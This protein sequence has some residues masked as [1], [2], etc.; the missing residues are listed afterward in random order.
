MMDWMKPRGA[1]ALAAMAALL[2]ISAEAAT[3]AGSTPASLTVT[4]A[5]AAVYQI[6][7]QVPP[8]VAGMQPKLVLRHDSQGAR[9]IAGAFW[10]LE[11]IP[12]VRRC[13]RTKAQDGERGGI[14]LTSGDRFCFDAQRLTLEQAG[15]YGADG[16]VYRPEVDNFSR[17]KS[18]GTAGS[19][20]KYFTVE[21]KGG[22]K[23]E[24]GNTTDSRLL[25]MAA[26][27]SDQSATVLTWYVNKISDRSGN[28]IDFSYDMADGEITLKEVS[29]AGGKVKVA[30]EYV[31]DWNPRTM[32]VAGTRIKYTKLL[33]K[34][35]TS[36][37]GGGAQGA[38]RT[39]KQYRL[40]YEYGDARGDSEAKQPIPR[41]TSVLECVGTSAEAAC[42]SPLQFTW[43]SWTPAAT[44]VSTP[45]VIG[46]PGDD[47]LKFVHQYGFGK[48]GGS[49]LRRMVDMNGDGYLDLVAF[50]EGGVYVYLSDVNG[51]F[52]AT[53]KQVST[54][55]TAIGEYDG[56]SDNPAD[57]GGG[58][59][60]R[61][62]VDLNG[63]GYPDI[64]GFSNI[65]SKNGLGVGGY[66]SYWNPATQAFDGN[67]TQVMWPNA[68]AG[69][70]HC[71][72]ATDDIGAPRYI[73]DMNGDGFPDVLRFTNG[74]G[75]V[76][77][78]NRDAK[79]FDDPVLVSADM[80]MAAPGW[81]G[82]SCA[83]YLSRQPI[84]LEDMNGDGYGDIV[85]VSYDGIFVMLWDPATTKFAAK[86]AANSTTIKADPQRDASIRM[87]D[88]NGDG[89]PDLVQFTPNE[90][91]VSLWSGTKFLD[92]TT[93]TTQLSGDY[94]DSFGLKNP[95]MLVDADG[96]GLPDLVA[97]DSS[98]MHVA[99]SNGSALLAESVWTSNFKTTKDAERDPAGNIWYENTQ[100]PRFFQDVDGDGYPD[101][102]G[103]GGFA[104]AI[105]ST[106]NHAMQPVTAFKDGFGAVTK[107]IY[108]FA[109]PT[110]PAK[111][112]TRQASLP[113]F[114]WRQANGPAKI[115]SYVDQDDGLDG[116]RTSKY[117]YTEALAHFDRGNFGFRTR[118]VED[119][120]TQTVSQ[121]EFDQLY[122]VALYREEQ[123]TNGILV[124]RTTTSPL[125]ERLGAAGEYSGNSRIMLASQ[126]VMVQRWDLSQKQIANSVTVNEFGGTREGDDA[127]PLVQWGDLTKQVTWD[128]LGTTTS[129]MSYQVDKANWL[130]GQLKSQ[131][132]TQSRNA[133]T[134]RSS[135]ADAAP[136]K[137]V[138]PMVK[139]I[140]GEALSAILSIL[141]DD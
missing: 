113:A 128:D 94:W 34:I 114:P 11:G 33:S 14:S 44:K 111:A 81:Y 9:G 1:T 99:I 138:Q 5:G 97:F 135:Y 78:W 100:T 117:R 48:E 140:S 23:L 74:G 72:G 24:F 129:V 55:F 92:A 131:K 73:L 26:S 67:E 57:A 71:Y 69:G 25:P 124:S 22:L 141:L 89:Y 62:L 75:Y 19:G 51:K 122:P 13:P 115:V 108:S 37:P 27:G 12:A 20:P 40:G 43:P 96:D 15:T 80:K 17:I 29:Y 109:Q 84:F 110:A 54:K 6:P 68:I 137:D 3:L 32:F 102:V 8:G 83:G 53:P 46:Q 139:P 16:V 45:F 95:R 112:Y 47:K 58:F 133:A 101:I 31:A 76:A 61:T 90:V 60:Y 18:I 66:V 126:S 39:V 38:D 120:N 65:T 103:F 125:R 36:L 82:Q 136:A 123:T 134:G 107:V 70:Q 52:P 86:G 119:L 2:S 63:D 104:I 21:E 85:G 41:L 118:S 93:W 91:R 132:V 7:I 64:L 121:R 105:A 106:T 4:D 10:S 116:V 49:H 130:I 79:R 50:G 56:W 88:M 77:Y 59:R 30:L 87:A 127:S 42:L 28:S 98:G 35:T